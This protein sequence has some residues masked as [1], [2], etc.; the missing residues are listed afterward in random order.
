MR[1]T[2][3]LITRIEDARGTVLWQMAQ[4]ATHVIDPGV[5]FLTT[6]LMEDVIDRGTGTAVRAAA[7]GCPLP[8]R[9]ARRTTRRTSGSSA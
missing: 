4:P 9:P 2:P 8:A 3:T 6:S 1:V 5:A 7:S